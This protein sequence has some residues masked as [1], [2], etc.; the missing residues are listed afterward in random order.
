MSHLKDLKSN[1]ALS[2][3]LYEKNYACYSC[4]KSKKPFDLLCN[5]QIT[6]TT[7]K[8]WFTLFMP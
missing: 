2:K 8:I 1:G 6:S 4:L 7:S 3:K 5:N